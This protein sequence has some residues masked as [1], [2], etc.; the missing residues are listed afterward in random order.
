[1]HILHIITGLKDGGAEAVLYRLC[2]ND[3][4][5]R[6]DVISLTNC[7]KYGPLLNQAGIEL[8]CLYMP[9]GTLRLCDLICLWGLIK[10]LRPDVVQ[11]W[12]YHADLVGG[13]TARLA[14][15]SIV[16]WGIRNGSLE[17]GKSK[18]ST[19]FLARICALFS[20]FV[21]HRIVCCAEGAVSFHAAIGFD[22]SKIVIIPN[23]Y[24]LSQF[25]P[26]SDSGQLFRSKFNI[27]GDSIVL[28]MV[29]RF[30]PQKDHLNLLHALSL[31][32]SQDIK[33]IIMLVG[34]GLGHDNIK[35]QKCIS[36]YSLSNEVKLLGPQSDIHA[37]MNALDFHVLSSAFGEAFP[38]VLAEA[39]ACGIPCITTDVGDAAFIVGDS[40]W[41][42]PHSN[43]IAMANSLKVAIEEP[44]RKR[45]ERGQLARK[46]ITISFSIDR[47]VQSYSALYLTM[48][49]T[50]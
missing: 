15:V 29:G 36:L 13:I 7:G 19:I 20:W 11:T 18:F 27:S 25:H 21:P 6:H 2:T 35:L 32:K 26:D 47:M 24:S 42:V 46:R 16:A 4:D 34:T 41:V 12:M 14:G 9:R 38:N 8:H 40:G 23:G 3:P 28:G 31:L 30:D 33:F 17:I 43:P 49:K 44:L 37:V 10:R 22:T 5:N 50:F 1:M 39:M 48:M 45:L